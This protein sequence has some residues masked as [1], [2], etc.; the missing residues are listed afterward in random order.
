MFEVPEV[1]VP[2]LD[3]APADGPLP[4]GTVVG[5]SVAA[6][7]GINVRTLPFVAAK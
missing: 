6:L 5:E 1:E 7:G 3:V 2:P 4:E